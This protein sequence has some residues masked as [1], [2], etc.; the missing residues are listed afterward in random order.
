MKT[1]LAKLLGISSAIL[2]FYGPLLR[3]LMASGLSALLPVAVDIV[4]SL[5][6]N[7]TTGAEK[8]EAAVRQLQQVAIEQGLNA[9]ESA[10]RFTVESA[11]SK[12][13]LEEK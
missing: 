11:Y 13:K 8:R 4:R 2:N 1:L 6:T 9:A 12:F 5:A 10:L 7:G 3:Q